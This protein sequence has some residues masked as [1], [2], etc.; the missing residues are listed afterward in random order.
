MAKSLLEALVRVVADASVTVQILLLLKKNQ[1]RFLELVKTCSV[2]DGDE[3]SKV[4]TKTEQSLTD[5]IEE[6]EEF[7]ATKEKLLT[8]TRMCDLIH[9]GENYNIYCNIPTK[10]LKRFLIT[11]VFY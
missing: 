9:P 8:F 6:I 7:Q 3:N 10:I 11:L 5:R 1:R 4:A 2:V